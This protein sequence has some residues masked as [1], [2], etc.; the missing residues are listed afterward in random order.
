MAISLLGYFY[1]FCSFDRTV[2]SVPGDEE[3]AAEENDGKVDT[4][5]R[6]GDWVLMHDV[7]QATE[8][9]MDL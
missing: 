3:D 2:E 9:C 5:E 1:R 7:P 6:T 8:L 4:N